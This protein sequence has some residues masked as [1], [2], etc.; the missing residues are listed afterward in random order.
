[1]K[2]KIEDIDDDLDANDPWS[3]SATME[4]E[5]D[6]ALRKCAEMRAALGCDRPWPAADLFDRLA[7]ASEHLLRDS[8]GWEEIHECC[9]LARVSAAAIR[10]ALSSD[11]GAGWHSPE[12]W[13]QACATAKADLA[14]A[15][16]AADKA[17]DLLVAD[18]TRLKEAHN[19]GRR[20]VAEG[21]SAIKARDA[22]IARLTEERDAARRQRDEAVAEVVR[23][24]HLGLHPMP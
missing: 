19:E 12:E 3:R 2:G 7:N 9:R 10:T 22:D 24:A 15:L 11:A 16:A 18:I 1:M 23:I 17:R 14:D 13:A 21:L 4:Q 20:L 5:R 8:H 6:E